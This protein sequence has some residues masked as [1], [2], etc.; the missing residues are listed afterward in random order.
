M[1]RSVSRGQE[2]I[3]TISIHD[4]DRRKAAAVDYQIG[5]F[6]LVKGLNSFANLIPVS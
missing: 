2:F 4:I 1:K 3:W 5:R 6:R